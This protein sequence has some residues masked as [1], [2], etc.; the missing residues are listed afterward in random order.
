M[1]A[2]QHPP[3]PPAPTEPGPD[4]EDG[5]DGRRSYK[6]RKAESSELHRL[7]K[8]LVD[9]KPSVLADL[10]LPDDVRE[11]VAVARARERGARVRELRR[12]VALLR[13]HGIVS[14]DAMERD[15]GRMRRQRAAR[16]QT[17]EAWRERLVSEG[18]RAL[19]ELVAQAPAADA[20]RLRQ[21]VRQARREP[22]SDK[23]KLALR[24]VLRLVRQ[25]CE[26]D[27]VAADGV[28]DADADADAD[29]D[30]DVDGGS[31]APPDAAADGPA[32]SEADAP[33]SEPEPDGG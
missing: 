16:E 9:A 32:G 28:A 12:V 25:A 29:V 14:L 21:L 6:E 24:S 15:A 11:V 31:D 7:A 8:R 33:A 26:A 13:A 23:A 3:Q 4:D 19:A 18:D 30:A 17:Y 22:G 1:N 10:P 20:Q 27:G 5:D 2:A